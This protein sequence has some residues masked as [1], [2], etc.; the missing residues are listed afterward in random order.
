MMQ[1]FADPVKNVLLAKSGPTGY[2]SD[3]RLYHW[4]MSE[5]GAPERQ[6]TLYEE[7]RSAF[8]EPLTLE[9]CVVLSLDRPEESHDAPEPGIGDKGIAEHVSRDGTAGGIMKLFRLGSG[10]H[11]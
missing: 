11:C 3:G 8:D 7:D 4:W 9:K 1:F 6:A 10:T 2:G 5:S